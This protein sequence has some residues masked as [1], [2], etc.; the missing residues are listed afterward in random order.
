M[1]VC[2]C[3]YIYIYNFFVIGCIMMKLGKLVKRLKLYLVYLWLERSLP[4][5]EVQIK[6]NYIFEA[7]NL[8][9]NTYSAT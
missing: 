6:F 7:L 3:V 5:I 2:V 8:Y 1:C 9:Y 4:N